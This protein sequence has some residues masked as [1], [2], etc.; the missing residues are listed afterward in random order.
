[1][2]DKKVFFAKNFNAASC[3]G[4]YTADLALLPA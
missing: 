2:Y 4:H 3:G 1:M